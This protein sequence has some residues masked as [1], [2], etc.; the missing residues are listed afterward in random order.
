MNTLYSQ[1]LLDAPQGYLL[2][3]FIGVAFGFWL[4]RAGF[5]SSRKLAGIFYFTDFA[6]LQVMFTAIVT[7]L[8]GL[9]LC[10]LFGIVD[11][12]SIYRMQTF[13][14]PQIAGGA[15]FGVGFV[16]GGWCPGTAM[17]GLVSGKIDALVFLAGATLGSLVYALAYPAV[18]DF[19][20]SGRQ[21]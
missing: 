18:A 1:G 16:A 19:A 14:W 15:L 3:A 5:G 20:S 13:L 7:A 2:A 12:S 10:T 21:E 4:E 11:A 8:L 17:V 9:E 6:V